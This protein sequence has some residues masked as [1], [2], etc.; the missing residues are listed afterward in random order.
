MNMWQ[1]AI[2]EEREE[3]LKEGME[4]GI[5]IGADMEH[6]AA[7]EAI[8]GMVRGFMADHGVSADEAIR[9]FHVPDRYSDSVRAILSASLRA[10]SWF[11]S[12][13]P[14]ASAACRRSFNEFN[15]GQGVPAPIPAFSSNSGPQS[16]HK[17]HGRPD[18]SP[19]AYL[20]DLSLYVF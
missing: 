19:D 20:H 12:A 10:I 4:K 6:K 13:M 14:N 3:G 2:A 8:A 18:P 9:R 11:P 5:E 17:R 16:E 7:V 1:E 15:S